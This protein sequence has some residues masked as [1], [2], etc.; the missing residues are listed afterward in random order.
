MKLTIKNPA[1]DDDSQQ[2]WGDFHFG[3][4][5]QRSLEAKGV[6]VFQDFQP[7]WSMDHGE[8][9]VL[10]LRGLSKFQPSKAKFNI[11]WIISHP[12]MVTSEELDAYDLIL[13]VSAFHC[14][15]LCKITKTPVEI[16]RHC[17]DFGNFSPAGVSLSEEAGPREGI[18]YVANSRGQR[19]EMA[20]WIEETNIRV[21][22]FGRAW[23]KFGV[24]H[25]VEKEYLPNSDL[26]ELY[27]S[28]RLCLND[29]WKDMRAFG[30]I[31]N[32]IFDSLA[33][34]LPLL[35]DSF[36]EIRAVFGDT[37]LYARN[38]DEFRNQIAFCESN[39]EEV[40]GRVRATWNEVGYLYTFDSRADEIIHWIET[41]PI[42]AAK[43][44]ISDAEVSQRDFTYKALLEFVE[45]E[46]EKTGCLEKLI[47]NQTR[48]ADQ[49]HRE[50]IWAKEQREEERRLK[51]EF[52]RNV[53]RAERK[54]EWMTEK[55]SAQEQAKHQFQNE[56]KTAE[57]QLSDL[58][59]RLQKEK[60]IRSDLEIRLQKEK[61]IR[62]S[63]FGYAKRLRSQLEM[64][65]KSR[66]WKIG[67]PYRIIARAVYGLL[68]GRKMGKARIPDW[69]PSIAELDKPHEVSPD[70]SKPEKSQPD[71]VQQ[72]PTGSFQ[73]P[74]FADQIFGASNVGSKSESAFR[75]GRQRI[76]SRLRRLPGSVRYQTRQIFLPVR[77]LLS[78]KDIQ[79]FRGLL[80]SVRV[81]K[82][83]NETRR[84][85]GNGSKNFGTGS[86]DHAG[87]GVQEQLVF[88]EAASEIEE[89]FGYWYDRAMQLLGELE[90]I[91]GDAVQ[92]RSLLSKRTLQKHVLHKNGAPSS[93]VDCEFKPHQENKLKYWRDQA[94]QL[95]EELE[96]AKVNLRKR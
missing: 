10:A 31:N 40:L 53:E 9:V 88:R 80:S 16:A 17:T 22:V 55:I 42:R 11:L 85:S 6:T 79:A 70:A 57:G 51:E 4:A 60:K 50:A 87:N 74:I 26:P 36:P 34:G 76:H 94:L 46:E 20:Q 25:L 15:L 63:L 35:T 92:K 3:N 14:D 59:I 90:A 56:L 54:I 5:L 30:F 33:C 62:I 75:R 52:R 23:E 91:Q 68:W 12:A 24:G 49:S 13:T 64:V 86:P 44:R 72:V 58:E 61:N 96:Y 69:P 95:H 19:R 18:V 78:G 1:P 67:A 38:A 93:G 8:D 21:R 2:R 84:R 27:R 73:N 81:N 43:R 32:R 89:G 83:E 71:N 47:T 39:Y 29:H 37:L 65:Y 82:S 28:A 45:Q 66:S 48:L 7:N 41:P 77:R